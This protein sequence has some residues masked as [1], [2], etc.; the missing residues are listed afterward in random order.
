MNNKLIPI[1]LTLVVG[2]I[3]AG[4][5]LMPVLNDAQTTLGNP[6]T[7]NNTIKTDSP[8]YTIWDGSDIEF[9]YSTSTTEYTI[10]G[11]T[12]SYAAD[13]QRILIASN[14]FACRNGG[15]LASPVIVSQY[16]TLD[17][18]LT[19]PFTFTVADK[20]YTLELDGNTY[21][22]N[23]DW[24]VYACD[25]GNANLGQV[26]QNTTI[27]TSNSNGMIVLGNIYTTGDND[28]FYSYYDGDLTVNSAYADS[29][30]IDIT[31]TLAD[32]YTDIY[33]TAITVNVGDESFTP[34]FILIP[35]TVEGHAAAGA[36]YSLVGAIPVMVIVALLMA[37]VGAIAL[38]RND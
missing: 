35:K 27:Y 28:T 6:A 18:Q 4:S 1:V 21:T 14:D 10:N 31:K 26:P 23:V 17:S 16:V 32:G 3:L 37:A 11:V 12:Y 19:K 25:E 29:S 9:E 36:T 15:T 34:F 2:I 24:L 38:R 33:Q 13:T 8:E 5:V 7:I 30:S 22:G 20:E